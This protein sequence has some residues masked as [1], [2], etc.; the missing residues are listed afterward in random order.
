[1]GCVADLPLTQGSIHYPGI[2]AEEVPWVFLVIAVRKEVEL[3]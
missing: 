1:M 3:H 2:K